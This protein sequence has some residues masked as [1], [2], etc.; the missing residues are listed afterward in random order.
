MLT[1]WSIFGSPLMLG[2]ELTDLDDWTR[3]LITNDAVIHLL[4]Y[5]KDAHQ[6]MRTYDFVAWQATEGE[7]TYVALFNTINWPDTFSVSLESLGL[8]GTYQAE[9]LWTGE[10]LGEITGQLQAQIDSHDAKLY[11]LRKCN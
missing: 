9:D 8:S 6:V 1:L 4:K 2:C 10:A 11:R 5:G 7:D 3:D